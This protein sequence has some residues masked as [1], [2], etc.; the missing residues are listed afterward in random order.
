ME[1]ISALGTVQTDKGAGVG[2]EWVLPYPVSFAEY[3]GTGIAA[4][5]RP[6]LSWLDGCAGWMSWLDGCPGWTL[7][8]LDVLVG[9]LSWLDVLAGWL[10]WLDGCPG[11]MSWLDG[12]VAVF[13]RLPL[14]IPPAHCLVCLFVVLC[15]SF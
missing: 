1:Q 12:L 15:F 4:S 5:R 2:P 13:G 14:P 9:R 6:R 11:W 8:W 10:S 3:A 7:S